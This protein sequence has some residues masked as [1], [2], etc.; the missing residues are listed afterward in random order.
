[1]A[2]CSGWEVRA[3]LFLAH[4]MILTD[5]RTLLYMYKKNYFE[6]LVD[7]VADLSELS[8][9]TILHG[10]KTDE[11]VDARW[12]IVQILKEQGYHTTKIAQL[13]GMSQRNVTHIVTAF[14]DRLGQ[15]D[16]LFKTTYQ[17]ARI[18]AGSLKV[19]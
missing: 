8:A 9:Y 7:V 17:K 11:V 2:K 3:F 10:R 14:Q 19:I 4:L 6:R 15:Y 16:S 1:M 13:M 5:K 18:L 12:I